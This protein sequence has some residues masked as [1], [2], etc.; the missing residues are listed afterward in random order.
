[1]LHLA[2]PIMGAQI[3][4]LGMVFTDNVMVARLGEK[5]L[6]AMA[7]AGTIY[8]TCYILAMGILSALSPAISHAYGAKDSVSIGR[9]IRQ[10]TRLS[11]VL[12]SCVILVLINSKNILVFLGQDP[13][14]AAVAQT[15]LRALAWGVPGQYL[16]FCGRTLSEGTSDS[17]P[18]IYIAAI[19]VLA[20]IGLDYLLIYGKLGF[21]A[22]GVA[23]AGYAT[24]LINWIMAGAM[25]LYLK[26]H[27]RYKD[28]GIFDRGPWFE[29]NLVR[30]F[31][32]IGL[33]ISGGMLAEMCFFAGA[34]LLMGTLGSEKLAAH[35]I[36]I[37][38]ASLTFMIPLGLAF[39]V[40]IRVGQF[41]GRGDN[42]GMVR[43]GRAG[44]LVTLLMQC[45]PGGL[46][47]LFPE[48]VTSLYT[49]DPALTERAV[50]LLRVGGIFQIFDGLQVVGISALR[51]LRDTKIPFLNTVI[52]FWLLGAPLA[53]FLMKRIGP[54]GVWYG[55]VIGLGLASA[56][57]LLRFQ[58]LSRDLVQ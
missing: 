7:M 8:S 54:V 28:F 14:L 10:G 51:G 22:W 1:M 24:S 27:A 17:R 3:L 37:N 9:W 13:E 43:A 12:S 26:G 30:D 36:A 5:P 49:S 21:P 15:F 56:F 53:I 48:V 20:N 55:M 4:T 2:W 46:F 38:A 45:L 19:G 32:R 50:A 34:T 31:I 41:R 35:Q 11:F 16:Y 40:G 52:S 42:L 25:G 33:P 18:S 6:A 39:A 57:H 23:G 44:F 29:K 58:R 47:L